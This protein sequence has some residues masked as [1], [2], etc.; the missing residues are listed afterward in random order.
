MKRGG[1]KKAPSG[2]AHGGLDYHNPT[3]PDMVPGKTG[4]AVA[5]AAMRVAR[6]VIGPYPSCSS[7]YLSI[8]KDLTF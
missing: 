8:S 5:P 4:L 1:T 7:A 3:I 2:S 6:T